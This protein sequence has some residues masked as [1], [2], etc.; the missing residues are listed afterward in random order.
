M[1]EEMLIEGLEL[2]FGETDCIFRRTNE[3]REKIFKVHFG[4]NSF[5]LT[6][7]W[8]EIIED[9]WI[10]QN[11]KRKPQIKHFLWAMNFLYQYLEEIVSSKRFKCDEKT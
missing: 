2:L 3:Y 7:L 11:T 5:I 1:P 6:I 4:K 10:Q 8:R 9:R